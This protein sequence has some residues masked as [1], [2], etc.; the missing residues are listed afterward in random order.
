MQVDWNEGSIDLAPAGWVR[1]NKRRPRQPLTQC[2]AGWLRLWTEADAARRA[3]EH[4]AAPGVGAELGIAGTAAA[5]P[6]C[7]KR[8]K[9]WVS[10]V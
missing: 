5:P 4:T 1:T 2:L 8:L 3:A 6:T 7:R 10:K 9:H